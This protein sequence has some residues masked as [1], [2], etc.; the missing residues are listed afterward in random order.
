MKELAQL[1]N[2]LSI[3]LINPNEL[4]E[5]DLNAR[6]MSSEAFQQLVH[7]IKKRGGI[8]SLPFCCEKDGKIEIISGH[9][10]VKAS[11]VAEIKEIPILLDRS[12]LSR[13]QIIAKQLAHNSLVGKDD[14]SILKQLYELMDSVDDKL[15]SFINV[16]EL[17]L[18]NLVKPTPINLEDKVSF[19]TITLLFTEKECE[20][21]DKVLE[22]LEQQTPNA[23]YV[24]R[25]EDFDG[26]VRKIETA[27]KDKKVRNASL[28]V[29]ILVN[30]IVQ[31]QDGTVI[32]GNGVVYGNEE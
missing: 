30:D 21:F 23:I 16:D 2:G 17:E 7:N 5:Q 26:M 12:D 25:R 14:D 31:L 18:D 19:K 9:N 29:A 22:T 10:R 8:E 24:C 32:D 20:D 11:K 13:S 28:A 1:G 27:K 6:L 15:E 3:V 4:R